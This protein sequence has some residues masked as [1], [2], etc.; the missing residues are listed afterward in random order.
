MGFRGSENEIRARVNGN[1]EVVELLGLLSERTAQQRVV[2]KA[3]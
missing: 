2:P 1:S 3:A